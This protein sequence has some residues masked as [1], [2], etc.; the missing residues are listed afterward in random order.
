MLTGAPWRL[1]RQ[2]IPCSDAGLCLLGFNDK[3]EI[4]MFFK[5]GSVMYVYPS[6]SESSVGVKTSL[7]LCSCGYTPNNPMFSTIAGVFCVGVV[8]R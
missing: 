3:R 7:V 8:Y 2:L 4:V 5:K 6:E 1:N